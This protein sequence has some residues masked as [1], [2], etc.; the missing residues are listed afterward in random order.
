MLDFEP[1]LKYQETDLKLR[2]ILGDIEKSEPSRK[3]SRARDEFN[4]AKQT[5]ADC[6]TAAAGVVSF[7]SNAEQYL[8]ENLAKA[9]ELL[10]KLSASE[11]DEEKKKIVADL[12]VLREKFADL[13]KRVSDRKSKGDKLINDY[14]TG[15]DKGK[16]MRAAYAEFKS[17]LDEIKKEKQAEIDALSSELEK[18]KKRI[19]PEIMEQ[20]DALA[21]DKKFP[22][23]VE[24]TGDGVT[25]TCRGCGLSLSQSGRSELIEKGYCRCENC[26]RVIYKKK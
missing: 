17:R 15:Q 16:R 5:V 10:Q 25:Y 12:E 7:L 20:Y 21:E 23:F 14:M 11:S 13:E 4:A 18:L 26:R 19:P 22:P 1:I 9:E 24:A 8:N 6:E 3:L 2:R